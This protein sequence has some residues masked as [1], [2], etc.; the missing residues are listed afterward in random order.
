[1]SNLTTFNFN[2]NQ[3]RT[4]LIDD[5]PWFVASDV[6]VVLGYYK[7]NDLTRI[8]DDFEKGTHNLRTLGGVQEVVVINES[9]LYSAT[10]R[11]RKPEAKVFKKWVTSEVLPSIRKTGSYSL[12]Q[13]QLKLPQTYIEAL[14]ALLESEKEKLLLQQENEVMKP[15]AEYFDALVDRNLLTNFR[16]TAKELGFKQNEFIQAL[17]ECKFIYRDAANTIKPYAK[18]TPELFELKERKTENKSGVQTLITPRGRETFR[19]LI[20][21]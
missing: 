19:L 21:K 15:K 9:G 16:D 14:E 6:A 5:E 17:L 18:Y 3:V 12:A 13:E 20:C 1:M 11:S 4:V 10:L 7:T 8:L 2:D